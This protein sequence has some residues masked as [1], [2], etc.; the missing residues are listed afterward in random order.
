MAKIFAPNKQYTGLS[1]SIGFVNG[2]G[3]T[4]DKDLLKWFKDH[5]Y[6]IEEDKQEDKKD[7]DL[8]TGVDDPDVIGKEDEAPVTD[9]S[10]DDKE[11]KKDTKKK[12]K[13]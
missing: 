12:N 7:E 3:E 13:K 11:D 9:D 4:E 1:A 10:V 6:D 2:V 8:A 5:G